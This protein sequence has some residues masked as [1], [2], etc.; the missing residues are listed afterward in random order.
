MTTNGAARRIRDAL[1]SKYPNTDQRVVVGISEYASL[2]PSS[3]STLVTKAFVLRIASSG[4]TSRQ[5]ITSVADAVA[6]ASVT[7]RRVA[8]FRRAAPNPLRTFKPHSTVYTPSCRPGTTAADRI[9][10]VFKGYKKAFTAAFSALPNPITPD[11]IPILVDLTYA[12]TDIS[13]FFSPAAEIL[14]IAADSSKLAQ[15]KAARDQLNAA[16]AQAAGVAVQA[17]NLYQQLHM[18]AAAAP[19]VL[20]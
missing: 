8:R 6:F 13:G 4:A 5:A 10:N 14:S 16:V 18:A 9:G 11:A 3:A 19:V 20:R 15:I 1:R 7:S 2:G 12:A 17:N